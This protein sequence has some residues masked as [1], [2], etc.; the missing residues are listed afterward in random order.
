MST[1][2]ASSRRINRLGGLE[3]GFAADVV[4]ASFD[5]YALNEIDLAPEYRFKLLLHP[6]HVEQR[7]ARAVFEAHEKVYVAI[8]PEILPQPEPKMASCITCQR[9]Q[10]AAISSRDV[11]TSKRMMELP[12]K[13][14]VSGDSCIFS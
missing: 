3:D 13:T 8:G 1:S 14:R 2:Q 6:D 5:P 4:S 9:S 12:R 10:K 7:M 11:S